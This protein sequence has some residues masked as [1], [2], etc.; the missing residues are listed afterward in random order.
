MWCYFDFLT[1]LDWSLAR[2]PIYDEDGVPSATYGS[3]PPEPIDLD[4]LCPPPEKCQT[5]P[6]PKKY[7]LSCKSGLYSVHE[8]LGYKDLE[9]RPL[10]SNT[11]YPGQK[12][13][14]L[15]ESRLFLMLEVYNLEV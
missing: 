14:E 2:P 11:T 1:E 5:C 6:D 4:D 15:S 9:V 10:Q 3:I 12:K 7:S 8:L 13:R